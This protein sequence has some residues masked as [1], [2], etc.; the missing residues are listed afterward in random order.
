[1]RYLQG[2]MAETEGTTAG[3]GNEEGAGA[4]RGAPTA[5]AEQECKFLMSVLRDEAGLENGNGDGG[6]GDGVRSGVGKNIVAM[7]LA[8]LAVGVFEK[9]VE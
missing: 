6:E 1:M 4:R 9:S 3:V 7:R 8:G 5:E 2:V